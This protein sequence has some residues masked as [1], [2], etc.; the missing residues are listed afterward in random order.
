MQIGGSA[1]VS[2]LAT[3]EEVQRAIRELGRADYLRLLKTARVKMGG[4]VFTDPAELVDQALLTPYKAASGEGGRRWKK[5]VNF[6]AF[7][8]K[9]IQGLASDSRNAAERR[10]TV[11]NLMPGQEG[12]PDHDLFDKPGLATV[13]AEEQ[14]ITEVDAQLNEAAERARDAHLVKVKEHF[15]ND[16]EVGWIM[17]G[18]EE[19]KSAQEIQSLSGMSATRYATARRR[20]RR[21]LETLAKERSTS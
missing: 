8:M 15:R 18:I 21:G 4:S 10:L 11:S 2:D 13:S 6:V 1:D 5:S 12:E 20:W 9:T 17:R 3:A 19:D 7:V 14:V 16:A